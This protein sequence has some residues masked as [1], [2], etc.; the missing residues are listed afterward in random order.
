MSIYKRYSDNTKCIFFMT[1]DETIFDKYMAILEKFSNT[2]KKICNS[3]L[4]Y[5][6]SY[7]K[8]G[9]KR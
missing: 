5:N 2:V 1:K 7:L 8:A 4:I 6:K 9:K 3:E